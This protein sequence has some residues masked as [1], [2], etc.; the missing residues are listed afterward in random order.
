MFRNPEIELDDLPD[1]EDLEWQPMHRHYVRRM[2]LERLIFAF[3]LLAAS[4][5]PTIASG[6]K[7]APTVPLWVLA[8]IFALPYLSWPL[9]SVPRRGYV[10]RDKDI[11]FKSGVFWR[12]VTAVPFNRVQHVETSNTP[13]DRKFGLANLQIFTAG[14][15]GGDLSISGLGADIAEQLRVYILD[16]VGASIENH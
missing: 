3:V 14:G 1:M 6:G 12:S 7:F 9:V 11:V 16:K 2:L 13:L 8:I 15:S 4:F 10:V 5:V